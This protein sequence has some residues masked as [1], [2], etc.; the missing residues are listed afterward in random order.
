MNRTQRSKK[1][2]RD[3]LQHDKCPP[4]VYL[5]RSRVILEFLFV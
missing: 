5:L 3:H 2:I 1:I 4:A